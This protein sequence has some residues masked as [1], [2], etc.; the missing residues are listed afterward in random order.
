[1]STCLHI[2]CKTQ[3]QVLLM[4]VTIKG[5]QMI[6]SPRRTWGVMVPCKW[7]N[8]ALVNRSPETHYHIAHGL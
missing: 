2:W 8:I 7:Q 5:K 1:M 4:P 3:N 6:F